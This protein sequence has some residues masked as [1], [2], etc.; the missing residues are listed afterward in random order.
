MLPH[1]TSIYYSNQAVVDL[2]YIVA[3]YLSIKLG[4]SLFV[5]VFKIKFLSKLP[6]KNCRFQ[7]FQG[8]NERGRGTQLPVPNHCGGVP[9]IP[10]ILVN[11]VHLLPKD[12][13]FKY[14]GRAP[15]NLVTPLK[16]AQTQINL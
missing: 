13:R 10:K 1:F 2:E 11:T 15:S 8:R 4:R 16:I 6:P 12:L 7:N 5:L 3:H 9:K 14:W